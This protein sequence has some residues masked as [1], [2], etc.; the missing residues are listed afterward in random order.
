MKHTAAVTGTA[1]YFAGMSGGREGAL[2]NIKPQ[3][4]IWDIKIT[5]R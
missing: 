2:E 4:R 1:Y 5:K 3:F